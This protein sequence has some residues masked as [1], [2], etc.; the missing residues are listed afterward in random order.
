MADPMYE[1]AQSL[2]EYIRRGTVPPPA[3]PTLLPVSWEAALAAQLRGGSANHDLEGHSVGAARGEARSIQYLEDRL[4]HDLSRALGSVEGGPSPT[5][6]GVHTGSVCCAWEISR[7]QGL[8]RLNR[9]AGAWLERVSYL[10]SL[11]AIL[12]PDYPRIIGPGQRADVDSVTKGR[13]V[14]G[15]I[16]ARLLGR[17]PK[18][19]LS[20]PSFWTPLWDAARSIQGLGS[21]LRPDWQAACRRVLRDKGAFDPT[22][23]G[24]IRLLVPMHY[25]TWPDGSYFGWITKGTHGQDPPCMGGGVT[26][27]REEYLWPWEDRSDPREAGWSAAARRE[28]NTIRAEWS[29]RQEF[30]RA[31]LVA[32]PPG[33]T[34]IVIG[35]GNGRDPLGD[36]PPAASGEDPPRPPKPSPEEEEDPMPERQMVPEWKVRRWLS[37]G[38]APP[39]ALTYVPKIVWQAQR[40]RDGES[41]ALERL[42]RAVDGLRKGG[43]P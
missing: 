15:A 11:C 19:T 43:A 31:D 22:K 40:R 25:I 17:E 27:G 10:Q 9:L 6:G 7:R 26:Q 29:Y 24:S 34:E 39:H 30:A 14:E 4:G 20:G 8:T 3:D 38:G 32:L 18:M 2:G 28:G 5:Y 41:R 36:L 23:A 35:E 21:A 12:G 37:G 1:A 16:L 33:G 42:A 13:K